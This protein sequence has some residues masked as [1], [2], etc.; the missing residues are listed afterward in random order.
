MRPSDPQKKV[1]ELIGR[2]DALNG[3]IARVQIDIKKF[4]NLNHAVAAREAQ[5]DLQ[6]LQQRL[7]VIERELEQLRR[8]W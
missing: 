8:Y 5:A 6:R 4:L 1:E 3:E 2:R 7:A